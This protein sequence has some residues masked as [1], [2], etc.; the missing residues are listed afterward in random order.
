M[1]TSVLIDPVEVPRD[2]LVVTV[3]EKVAETFDTRKL[4]NALGASGPAGP[5]GQPG[6]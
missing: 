4:T 6:E 5:A 3:S 1:L 2:F